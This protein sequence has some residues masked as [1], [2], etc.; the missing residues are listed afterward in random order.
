MKR[1]F[2]PGCALYIYKPHI[3]ESVHK[4]LKENVCEMDMYMTCCH[5]EPPEGTEKPLD[6]INVCSGCD[7][8]YS[9]LYDGVSTSS[10][11]QIIAEA[12]SFPFPDYNGAEITVHDTC[13]TRHKTDVHEAVRTLLRKMNFKIVEAPQSGVNAIC[14]GDSFHK[15]IEKEEVLELMKKRAGSMPCDDVCVY[16]VSCIKSIKN[17]GKNPRYILDLLFGEETI[18]GETDPDKWHDELGVFID[19]H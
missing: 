13:P 7:R 8:R 11:W 1:T 4:F 12:D 6:I 17:G 5:H 9:S 16:C 14:C 10:L 2:A 19:A 18:P 3:A 15:K